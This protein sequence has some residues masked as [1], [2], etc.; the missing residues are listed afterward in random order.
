MNY[1]DKLD[2]MAESIV[3]NFGKESGDWPLDLIATQV[4]SGGLRVKS[5]WSQPGWPEIIQLSPA[6]VLR[7]TNHVP[8]SADVRRKMEGNTMAQYQA[9][10]A[11]IALKN[12][13]WD[14][15]GEYIVETE[16]EYWKLR[17]VVGKRFVLWSDMHL[18]DDESEWIAGSYEDAV[19]DAKTLAKNYAPLPCP[20]VEIVA[21][22]KYDKELTPE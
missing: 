17:F 21:F 14:R 13:L 6:I 15:L 18:H 2:I 7:H 22:N 16:P 9:T 4:L 5:G 19:R 10:A 20:D 8:G 11:W 12:D 3:G 1:F